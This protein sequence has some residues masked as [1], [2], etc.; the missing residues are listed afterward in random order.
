M[1]KVLLV[2]PNYY[3]QRKSGAWGIDPP[4]GLCYIAAVLEN[5]N[6]PVKILD[7]NI[8]NLKEEEVVKEAVDWKA[9]IV[10]VS[11]LTPAHNF[12]KK[13]AQSLPSG[14]MSVAGGPHATAVPEILLEDGF[15]VI[16]RGEGEETFLDLVLGKRL[17]EI[18]GISYKEGPSIKNNPDRLPPDINSLPMP[19]RH[20]LMNNGVD[21]PYRSGATQNFPWAVIITSR[22]CPYNCYYCN[23]LIFGRSLRARTPESIIKELDFLVNNY[24]IKEIS[25]ADDCF[26]F[27]L[28]NAKKTLREIISRNYNINIRFSNGL[29]ADKIDEEFVG[30]AKEAGC[31]YIGLGIESGSQEILNK[32]PKGITLEIIRNAVKIIKK[33][34]IDITGF[35]MFGLLGDTKETMQ[36]TI[37]FAKELDL[38]MA[39]FNIAMPYP[40]TRMWNMIKEQGGKIFIKDWDDFHHTAGKC[41]YSMPGMAEPEIIEYMYKK[42]HREF[43]FS[44]KYLIKHAPKFLSPKKIK[45]ALK[46]FSAII[47]TQRND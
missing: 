40:G 12:A 46:G 18:N 14:I 31:S 20:L 1:K 5:N 25:I 27:N 41:N 16:V 7:A 6:I 38:D 35:F 4:M 30:L 13:L 36:K 44:P 15:N 43:Y 34:K 23:K 10:G 9:D 19:A 2:Q 29:R 39:S 47:K 8:L 32:I 42:A 24:N 26:N 21:K 45:I 37:D 22:A 11:I 17:E 33:K 3:Y 28:E